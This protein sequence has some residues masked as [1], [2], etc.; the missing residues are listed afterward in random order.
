MINT[1]L[2]I[3]LSHITNSGAYICQVAIGYY[4]TEIECSF[5]PNFVP[6]T[7]NASFKKN[8][9]TVLFL[10]YAY[11]IHLFSQFQELI[12]KIQ[13]IDLISNDNVIKPGK[14]ST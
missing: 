1:S 13:K 14:L 12:A 7:A 11:N 4:Y 3:H 10:C 9:T 5:S 2:Y 8:V 6:F